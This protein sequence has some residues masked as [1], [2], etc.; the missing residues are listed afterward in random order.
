MRTIL[1]LPFDWFSYACTLSRFSC[2]GLCNP[3]DC[4]PPCSSVHGILQV[5]ILEWLAIPF[6]SGSSLLSIK[7]VSLMSPAWTGGFFTISATWETVRCKKG[8]LDLEFV[9]PSGGGTGT[10]GLREVHLLP[11][12]P[13][14]SALG[15]FSL[16]T[17]A[18]RRPGL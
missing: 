18:C 15:Q 11:I 17:G 7:P 13:A 6:S 5:R 16:G 9:A 12:P 14:P 1:G 10:P 4:S 3:M 2:V 8:Q